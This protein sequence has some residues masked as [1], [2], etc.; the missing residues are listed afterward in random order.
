MQ[1]T[2]NNSIIAD[3][4]ASLFAFTKGIYV[5]LFG[6]FMVAE[7]VAVFGVLT[8]NLMA[9]MRSIPQVRIILFGYGLLLYALIVSDLYN[10][11]PMNDFLRGWAS[12]I[13]G[14]I[15]TL[16]LT[17]QFIKSSRAPYMF[18]IAM[19]IGVIIFGEGALELSIVEEKSNYF[20]VR[21]EPF[22]TPFVALLACWFWRFNRLYAVGFIIA[23]GIIYM[24]F[25]ARSSGV[26]LLFSAVLLLIQSLD[27]RPKFSQIMAASVIFGALAY[28]GYVYYVNQVLHHG[29]GGSNAKQLERAANPYNPFELLFHG[30][31]E[32]VVGLEAVTDRPILGY[33]S[34]ARDTD[35]TYNLLA[36]TLAEIDIPENIIMTSDSLI[37]AHSVLVTS[38]LWAGVFGF[39]GMSVIIFTIVK[40][41][42]ESF[43][44]NVA[45]APALNIFVL[46]TIWACIFSP[47][48]HI[49]T[50][51]P[52]TIALLITC[53]Y[54][55]KQSQEEH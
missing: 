18:L 33:G 50:S 25:D 34:W 45:L 23:F 5:Q 7:F 24:G 27:M 14:V 29:L 44:A 26:V 43:W 40:M 48:G 1:N 21:F 42:Y 19:I 13:F 16:F 8:F 2:Q 6:Q 31:R 46:N 37:P 15:S 47:F 36:Y 55:L 22:L 53:S 4:L 49:R 51:F 12:I 28:T 9:L 38:W 17:A 52:F 32:V 20:K 54:F 41:F 11:T 10:G 35:G 39:L 30:R 3:I